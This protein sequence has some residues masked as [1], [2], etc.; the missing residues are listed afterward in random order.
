[1]GRL[2]DL[3]SAKDFLV[4]PLQ[5]V[6]MADTSVEETLEAIKIIGKSIVPDFVIDDDNSFLYTNLAKWLIGDR[7]MMAHDVNGREIQGDCKK[8]LYIAGTTGTG[9]SLAVIILGKICQ[10]ANVPLYINGEKN[11][12]MWNSY[13]CNEICEDYADSGDI[14]KYIKYPSICIQDLGAEIERGKEGE[15]KAETMYMGNRKNVMRTIL[16]S[17][18]DYL[19]RMTLITSNYKINGKVIQQAYG[20]RV[21]SRLGLMCNYFILKGED[22]RRK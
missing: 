18:G 17:R 10:A 7:S 12:L 13:L 21:V 2:C 1:M 9:K 22:R 6:K 19:D 3:V 11:K 8:G 16:E 4:N 5:R 14:V 20:D 15:A